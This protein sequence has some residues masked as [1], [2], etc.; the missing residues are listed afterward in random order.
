MGTRDRILDAAAQIMRDDGIARATT[1]EIAH[2]AGC[3]E[4][5]LYKHFGDKTD[6]FMAVLQER[7]PGLSEEL[8]SLDRAAGTGEVRSHLVR[9]TAA[10]LR[11]YD[12]SF[13][14][15]LG[16]FHDRSLLETFRIGVQL[17]GGGPASVNR[18]LAAY[19]REEREL[20]RLHPDTDPE[21][22]ACL[23]M[24]ACLQHAFFRHFYGHP[25]PDDGHAQ[26]ERLVSGV[27]DGALA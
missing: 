6:L 11:F 5:A 27:L 7:V 26:A 22:L 4:A 2:R 1:K 24:G 20:G 14:M 15:A 12:Q 10:A 17:R 19:L 16:M 23:L 13:P 21:A 25:A 8:A 3:S 9:V 18:A